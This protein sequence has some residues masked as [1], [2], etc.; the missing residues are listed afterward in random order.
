M[1]L[2]DQPNKSLPDFML[3]NIEVLTTEP[4]FL[5]VNEAQWFARQ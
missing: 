1:V 5:L 2:G 4:Q 3:L